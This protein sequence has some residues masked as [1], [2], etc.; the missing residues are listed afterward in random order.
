VPWPRILAAAIRRALAHAAGCHDFAYHRPGRRRI[1][2]VITPAMRRPVL[3]VAIVVDTSGSMAEDQLRDAMAE[4]KGVLA[5]AGVSAQRVLVLACDAAVGAANRVRRVEEIE[6]VGGGGTDLRVGISTAESSRPRPDVVVVFTDGL[7]PWP[8][9][10][11][12]ARLI[13]A[14]VGEP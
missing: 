14:V 4:V 12:R 3:N 1:P 7:T 2:R 6:L 5:A 9:R 11:T 13:V 10:P 8:E